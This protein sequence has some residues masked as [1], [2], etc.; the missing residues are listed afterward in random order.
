MTKKEQ[1]TEA[2]VWHL[3]YKL[4]GVGKAYVIVGNLG[5]I[6]IVHNNKADISFLKDMGI[7]VPDYANEK[8]WE[9]DKSDFAFFLNG[10]MVKKISADFC[11][12]PH[13]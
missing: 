8:H 2:L 3:N 1:M 11:A 13:D 9:R 4:K 5:W 7:S 6:G 10:E 12:N